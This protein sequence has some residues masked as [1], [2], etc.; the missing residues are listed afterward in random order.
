MSP[1]RSPRPPSTAQVQRQAASAARRSVSRRPP[2]KRKQEPKLKPKRG[3]KR[4]IFAVLGAVVL[5][6]V[7]GFVLTNPEKVER[8]L[9][10]VTLPLRHEDIIRQQA[11]DKRVEAP[12]IAAIINVEFTFEIRRPPRAPAD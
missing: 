1:A 4:K 2:P 6:A 7:V 10:E 9:R 12:L 8:T 5:G 3:R 11:K